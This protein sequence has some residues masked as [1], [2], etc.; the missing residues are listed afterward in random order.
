VARE[1]VYAQRRQQVADA[2]AAKGRALHAQMAVREP[3]TVMVGRT[4]VDAP[5]LLRRTLEGMGLLFTDYVAFPSRSSVIAVVTWTAQAAAR[6]ADGN[7]IWRAFVRLLLTSRLNGS[8]KSTVADIIRMLLLC[9]TGRM[10]KVTP[11]GLCKVLGTWKEVAIADDAQNTFRSDKA[12]AELLTVM[13][14]G[15]TPGATWV[16]GKSDGKVEDASGPLVIV[17]KDDLMTKRAEYLK[18]LI[19]RSAV[20]RMERPDHYMPEFDE[21][22]EARAASLGATLKAVTGALQGQL[23]QAA[24][25]L[26]AE[27]R[28]RLITDGDGG[29]TAQIWRPMLAVARV[30]DGDGGPWYE[31]TLQAMEELSAAGGDLLKAE[32]ALAELEDLRG[33]GRSFWDAIPGAA[34]PAAAE[35]YDDISEE[36]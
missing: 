23:R 19:D 10:S 17:G 21:E 27:N 29:R 28:G 6:D 36:E 25:E 33:D 32:E 2:G 30:A 14:N 11:Y 4:L 15:Y 9:R 20:V 26:A 7:S 18:D 22:A 34:K 35:D 3:G 13:I 1:A 31:A 12:G 8:G 16:S 5:A 24:R